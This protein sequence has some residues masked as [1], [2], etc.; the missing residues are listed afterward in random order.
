M[1]SRQFLA[2]LWRVTLSSLS[3]G[4]YACLNTVTSD[5]ATRPSQTRLTQTG[6]ALFGF[7]PI[8]RCHVTCVP[9]SHDAGGGR[10]S[11]AHTTTGRSPSEP[12]Q[13]DV[14][15]VKP[16]VLSWSGQGH[17]L[18]LGR[19]GRF[20]KYFICCFA[21]G[22]VSNIIKSS[23]MTV[24]SSFYTGKRFYNAEKDEWGDNLETMGH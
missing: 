11:Q 8:R 7:H 13:V 15:T 21:Q 17:K 24:S 18:C 6:T 10:S 4:Y 16:I 23:E 9:N 14:L 3:I 19:R 20:N 12:S 22:T 2:S 5:R 1:T